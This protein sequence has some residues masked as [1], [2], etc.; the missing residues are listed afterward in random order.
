MQHHAICETT[1]SNLQY[2]YTAG[3][4]SYK[5]MSRK[6]AGGKQ[7]EVGSGLKAYLLQSFTRQK[8]WICTSVCLCVRHTQREYKGQN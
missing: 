2:G 7:V 6:V 4:F 1:L 3:N 8:C 5:Q